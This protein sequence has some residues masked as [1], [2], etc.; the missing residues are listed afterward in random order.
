MT[1][2][3]FK[4]DSLSALQIDDAHRACLCAI[5]ALRVVATNATNAELLSEAQRLHAGLCTAADEIA[6]LRSRGRLGQ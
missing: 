2:S 3:D 4:L 6:E 5:G 1:D